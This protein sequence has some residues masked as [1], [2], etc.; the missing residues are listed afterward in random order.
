M[1]EK[2]CKSKMGVN[3]NLL[4]GNNNVILRNFENIVN[5]SAPDQRKKMCSVLQEKK[6]CIDEKIT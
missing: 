2:V 6:A 4:K 1:P 5:E 3:F